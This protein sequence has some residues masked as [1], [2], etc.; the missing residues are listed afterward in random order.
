MEHEGWELARVSG[1]HHIMGKGTKML[2]IPVH[3]RRE[4]ATGTLHRILKEAGLK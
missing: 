3:G 4:V 2:S 1:S